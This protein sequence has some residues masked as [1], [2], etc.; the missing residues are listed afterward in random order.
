[1]KFWVR[2]PITNP[3]TFTMRGI[4]LAAGLLLA[5]AAVQAQA[6]A[7]AATRPDVHK[8]VATSLLY[9]PEPEA[10]IF[11]K[12]TRPA[13]PVDSK[14]AAYP[15]S[16]KYYPPKRTY[17]PHIEVIERTY[18]VVEDSIPTPPV[19]SVPGKPPRGRK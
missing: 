15:T 14:L 2:F 8:Q 10:S 16:V 18:V 11:P 19:R 12:V 17:R 9:H 3:I 7:Q 13:V 1:V 4:L 5:T 6:T